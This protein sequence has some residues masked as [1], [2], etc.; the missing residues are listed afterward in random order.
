MSDAT[1]TGK[2]PP[3]LA[4]RVMEAVCD[5]VEAA[6]KAGGRPRSRITLDGVPEAARPA[7]FREL[8]VLEL[9]YLAGRA[10]GRPL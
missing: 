1:P 6:W 2:R 5:R 3:A 7:L 8:L 9:A 10:S 4:G